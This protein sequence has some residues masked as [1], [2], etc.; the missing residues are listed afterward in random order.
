MPSQT[1]YSTIN[2]SNLFSWQIWLIPCATSWAQ[3]GEVTDSVKQ[4]IIRKLTLLKC[5]IYIKRIFNQGEL[6]CI[7]HVLSFVYYIQGPLFIFI[8]KSVCSRWA[9][10]LA[11]QDEI[12]RVDQNKCMEFTHRFNN[13]QNSSQDTKSFMSN[14]IGY[15]HL[16]PRERTVSFIMFT[17]FFLTLVAGHDIYNY[18]TNI[19]VQSTCSTALNRSFKIP[20]LQNINELKLLSLIWVMRIT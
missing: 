8:F 10:A 7:W 3:C 6:L 19:D 14:I 5:T 4:N 11:C 13:M 18:I 2:K 16:R 20:I 1:S 17:Y 12:M 9:N 15:T